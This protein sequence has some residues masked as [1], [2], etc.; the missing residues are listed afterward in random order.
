MSVVK[1]DGNHISGNFSLKFKGASTGSN[2]PYNATAV[3]MKS[4]LEGLS[5]IP[6]GTLSVTRSGPDLQRG[7]SMFL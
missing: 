2:I 3:Q 7:Q 4:L 1:Y 6:A 5:T